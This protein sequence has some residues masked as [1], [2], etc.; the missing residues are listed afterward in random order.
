MGKLRVCF[1][2]GLV[3]RLVVRIL[4]GSSYFNCF[5]LDRFP[6]ERKI[7]HT[8]SG[9]V[10]IVSLHAYHWVNCRRLC[11][12]HVPKKWDSSTS[13][14]LVVKQFAIPIKKKMV[15]PISYIAIWSTLLPTW[16]NPVK[17]LFNETNFL[18]SGSC[19]TGEIPLITWK[20]YNRP[21]NFPR[22]VAVA[23]G[24][25]QTKIVMQ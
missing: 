4:V 1:K 10:A 9:L 11:H 21:T 24:V 6:M 20:L 8:H 23:A 2:F 7:V 18:E 5:I 17:D 15:V 3:D 14:S 16:G 19:H 13:S 25:N 22:H 12:P